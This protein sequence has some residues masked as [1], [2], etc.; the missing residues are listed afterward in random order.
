MA[1]KPMGMLN[2][3]SDTYELVDISGRQN[4][5]EIA[6][7]VSQLSA[8]VLSIKSDVENIKNSDVVFTPAE[9]FTLFD[10]MGIKSQNTIVGHISISGSTTASQWVTVGTINKTPAISYVVPL[11]NS[12][13]GSYCGMLRIGTTGNVGVYTTSS[14]SAT[15][16]ATFIY[17][18]TSN[19]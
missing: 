16:N 17:E 2:I 15:M 12:S 3:G 19:N 7:D 10:F 9:G 11:V 1:N 5:A 18:T 14:I 4:T 13:N 6:L 8:S